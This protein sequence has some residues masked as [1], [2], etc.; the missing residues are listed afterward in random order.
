M[1]LKLLCIRLVFYSLLSWLILSN[2][3]HELLNRLRS[4]MAAN[5][6]K[7]K[8][9]QPRGCIRRGMGE[10]NKKME[11]EK[12]KEKGHNNS[13]STAPPMSHF[14]AV[15]INFLDLSQSAHLLIS[16][17]TSTSA[18]CQCTVLQAGRSRVRFRHDAIDLIL[19]AA[20]WH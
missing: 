7:K 6:L 11:E 3:K 12:D 9:L 8:V 18:P 1:I 14:S 20:L 2:L 13:F 10:K 15:H 4:T 17:T 19:S 16:A 5:V